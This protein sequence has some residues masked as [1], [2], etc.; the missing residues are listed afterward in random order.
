MAD[1]IRVLAQGLNFPEGPAFAADGGLWCVEARGSALVQWQEDALIRHDSGGR[2]CGLAFDGDG[3]AWFCDAAQN[4]VRHFTLGNGRWV[5]VAETLDGGPLAAPNDLAFDAVGNLVFT[6]PGDSRAEPS[7]YVCCLRTDGRVSRIGSGLY[8]PNGVVFSADGQTLMVAETYGRRVWKGGWDSRAGRWLDPY[9]WAELSGDPGPDGMALGA[10]G[11]LYVAALRAG[12]VKA[13]DADGQVVA[14]YD[15]PGPR[16]TNVA[17]D[18][19]GRLGL[20]VTEAEHGLLLSLPGL[21]P[22]IPP[23]TPRVAG[24]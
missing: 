12:Q 23:F 10:D 7:G 17:F 11:L 6:C 14:A 21:G 13:M 2:A 8:F 4:A 15:V 20:V 19:A 9:P 24:S 16:P 18:P 22:G 1:A 3:R 5:T